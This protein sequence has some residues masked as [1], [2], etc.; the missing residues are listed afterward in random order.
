MLLGGLGVAKAAFIGG[1]VNIAGVATAANTTDSSS[2]ITGSLITSGGLGVAKA[3]FIGTSATATAAT[4]VAGTTVINGTVS[5]SGTTNSPNALVLDH[6]SSG[7]PGNGFG[8]QIVLRGKSTTTD[9]RDLGYMQA[10]WVVATDASRTSRMA[11]YCADTAVR[12]FLRGE[13]SGS[14]P[15]IGFL[16]TAAAVKQTS[17]AN[18]TNNVT[19]GGTTDQI[20]DFT[21]LTVY[22]TDAAAIRNDIYQLAR[23]LKQVND[24]LR[25]YG[26]LT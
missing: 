21:S 10:T 1:L 11:L 20:D 6:L 13:A 9:G 7:T 14:A 16:G 12:E 3:A 23:K 17:G 2:T 26:L 19:S 24:A 4:L 18:L 22:A 15:M 5:D 8:T 25:T